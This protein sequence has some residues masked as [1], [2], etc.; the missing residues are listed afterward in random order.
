MLFPCYL[1]LFA[2]W[3]VFAPAVRW[4]AVSLPPAQLSTSV[5]RGAWC[6]IGDGRMSHAIQPACQLLSPGADCLGTNCSE[7][8]ALEL[9]WWMD[10]SPKTLVGC[11]PGRVTL[12]LQVRI[13]WVKDLELGR[14]WIPSPAPSISLFL[15]S[16]WQ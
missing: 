6:S 12:K 13:G 1:M 4:T 11:F 5:E 14:Y 9:G 10:S 15:E 3:K 8:E 16:R 2:E 7:H